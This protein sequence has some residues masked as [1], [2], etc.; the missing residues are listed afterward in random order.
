MRRVLRIGTR[1]S[2]LAL[3]QARWVAT[4]LDAAGVASELV[5]IRTQGDDRPP[6][7]AWGEGA[8][9]R[10][11][12]GAL[13][14]GSIDIA[15]HS[16]KDVP[17]DEHPALAIAAYPGREDPRD[18]LVCRERGRTLATLPAGS[19]VGTDSPRRSAFILAVRPDLVL[20]PLHGNVDTRL[21]RL[22]EGETDALVLAV[23]GL[24]RLGRLDRIDEVLAPE[25]VTAAPGQGALAVQVRVEDAGAR[26]AVASID[27]AA[28][29]LAVE[30]E[31]A[32]LNRSGGGCRS[33]IGVTARAT[34]GRL[35]VLAAAERA[36]VPEA[37]ASIPTTRVGR[38]RATLD[39]SEPSDAGSIVGH[40]ATR[41]V[42]LRSGPRAVVG[43]P[44]GQAGPLLAAL[45][46]SG[47]DPAHVPAIE[48][49]SGD[50]VAPALH[51]VAVGAWVVLTSASA[52][53]PV[54]AALR[55]NGR[56]AADLRWAAVGEATALPLRDA[57]IADVFVPS[58]ADGVTMAR[59]LPVTAGVEALLVR[60]DLA[61]DELPAILA[62]RGAVVREVVA[63]RTLE[64]PA[65]SRPRL[66]AV[67]DDGP[68]DALVVTS[69]STAR[70]FAALAVGSGRARI[71]ATPVV[72]AGEASAREARAAGF[73]TVVVAPAP[74]A[75]SLA[76]FTA[77]ALGVAPHAVDPGAAP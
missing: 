67:L 23:A 54:L 16:A 77:R 41:V 14:D 75:A 76:A 29:R 56:R 6:D 72:A 37:T 44:E 59:E 32:I 53:A 40:V 34:D 61:G 65:S 21:R 27:D 43:R 74:D 69:G 2:T 7:T 63:Y 55:A 42:A 36:W 12:E 3:V 64:A 17:T 71:L 18:A 26:E 24:A 57:G 52:A 58:A 15:V 47:V 35:E 20:H 51:A 46:A 39:T 48:I 33:P 1:G 22:D 8:F 19:R 31:R 10:G 5:T 49:A 38:V 50:D 9:V 60:G 70:G 11:I 4:R 13:L 73:A 62:A 68:V 28:T 45:A 25:V 30:M 66:D